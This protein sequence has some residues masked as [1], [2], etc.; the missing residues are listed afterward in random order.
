LSLCTKFT[1]TLIHFI[2]DS[3]GD[4]VPLFLERQC[5]R[6]LGGLSLDEL[7]QSFAVIA[8]ARPGLMSIDH[9]RSIIPGNSVHGPGMG[10]EGFPGKRFPAKPLGAL[11]GLTKVH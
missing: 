11:S 9:A 6:T 10:C 3:L 1:A 4:S 2:L 8:E 7:L 5:D